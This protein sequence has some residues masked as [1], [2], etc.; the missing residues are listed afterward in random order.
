MT[1]HVV[2]HFPV[3]SGVCDVYEDPRTESPYQ[4]PAL[5]FSFAR[6]ARR[7]RRYPPDW[8]RLSDEQL[9]ELSESK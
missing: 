7:V 4:G 1:N 3:A 2:R 6:Y 9:L 8:Y 5:V